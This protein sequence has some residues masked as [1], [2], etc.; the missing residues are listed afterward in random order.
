MGLRS[1]QQLEQVQV[2]VPNM[3]TVEA[4]KTSAID[5][6]T[7]ANNFMEQKAIGDQIDSVNKIVVNRKDSLAKIK[8]KYAVESVTS[9][10][11]SRLAALVGDNAVTK[12]Q[13]LVDQGTRA[14]EELQQKAPAD[15]ADQVARDSQ[16]KI[17][18]LRE[19]MTDKIGT[20]GRKSAIDTGNANTKV[21][22]MEAASTFPDIDK[23]KQNY[24]NT[25]NMARHTEEMKGGSKNTKIFSAI[26]SGSNTVFEGVKFSLSQTATPDRVEE[27]EKYYK[28][29]IL[30]DPDISVT[31]E[32]Q[33][34]IN[35]ALTAAREKTANDAAYMLAAQAQYRMDNDKA[36]TLD[37]AQA[38]IFAGAGRVGGNSKGKVA[39]QGAALFN[40]FNKAAIAEV[41]RHDNEIGV[42]A[43][44][45]VHSGNPAEAEK[46]TKQMKSPKN[47]METRKYIKELEDGKLPAFSN[48]KR[49]EAQNKLWQSNPE[50]AAKVPIVGLQYNREDLYAEEARRRNFGRGVY[51]KKYGIDNG[52]LTARV[53]RRAHK[54]AQEIIGRKATIS[55]KMMASVTN[56]ANDIFNEERDKFPDMPAG[57]LMDRVEERMRD[58][59]TGIIKDVVESNIF[60]KAL[61]LIGVDT[62]TS[63]SFNNVKTDVRPREEFKSGVD[64]SVR[65][66]EP[67]EMDI[68]K[69]QDEAVKDG[70]KGLTRDQAREIMRKQ[71]RTEAE[72]AAKARKP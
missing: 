56:R 13:G 26:A 70:E 19:L 18:E 38:D 28:E 27:L 11:K 9:E 47:E 53:D 50:V 39:M 49:R 25:M 72:A 22:T 1:P 33:T 59:K 32:D 21:L 16:I 14:L 42:K 8:S 5:L 55:T 41:E 2:G 17:K 23:F 30:K 45:A 4:G 43:A 68:L 44:V 64:G 10:F 7:P 12:S 60:G 36:Y 31:T 51:E 20:E 6:A 66:V 52:E 46:L 67:T 15:L 57:E 24:I 71:R 48:P 35:D 61:S 65:I 63:P 54:I 29:V 34:K 62:S 40:Q 37:R 58:P 3:P 69:F